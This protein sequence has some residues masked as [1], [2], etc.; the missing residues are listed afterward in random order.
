VAFFGVVITVNLTMAYFAR[1]SWSGLVADDTFKAS[2]EFNG[3]A[4]H[5][6]EM[7]AT[8][9]RG[10]MIANREGIRYELTHPQT[11]PVE[12]DEVVAEFRRPVGTEQDFK[13]KLKHVGGGI[14][15]TDHPVTPGEWIVDLKTTDAG[16]VVYHEAI[17]VHVF[18]NR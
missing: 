14:F 7:A 3:K 16:T 2:Q 1:S 18:A 8:G 9:I 5:M 12:A 13:V 6:R 11:G 10:Q 17:R 4:E 15:T